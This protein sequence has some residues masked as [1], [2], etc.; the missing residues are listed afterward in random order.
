MRYAVYVD[1]QYVGSE[2]S[3]QMAQALVLALGEK[4]PVGKTVAYQIKL[5]GELVGE[6]ELVID[7]KD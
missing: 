2:S 5:G 1:G 4:L 7:A 3:V 6:G